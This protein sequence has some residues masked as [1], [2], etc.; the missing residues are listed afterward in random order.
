MGHGTKGESIMKVSKCFSSLEE[1]CRYVN[2][3]PP[4]SFPNGKFIPTDACDSH[5]GNGAG[6]VRFYPD[7][8]GG[9][10][11]NWKTGESAC[12]FYDYGSRTRLTQ[13]E[14]KTRQK[15]IREFERSEMKAKRAC[16]VAVAKVAAEI[17]E[18]AHP[19][20]THPYLRRKRVTGFLGAPSVEIDRADA[21]KL[22]VRAQI[23]YLDGKPQNLQYCESRLL[24]VPLTDETGKLKSLQFIDSK[25]RKTILKGTGAKGLVWRPEDLELTAERTAPIALCEGVATA[26][27]VRHLYKVPCVAAISACNLLEAARIMRENFPASELWIC[28]DRDESGIGEQKAREAAERVTQ[29]RL[30]LCP[31]LSPSELAS[32]YR[33]TGSN[34]CTDYNDYMIAREAATSLTVKNPKENLNG[35]N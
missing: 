30:F 2:I 22:L 10:T 31:E 20:I 15:L 35:Y 13:E 14:W 5:R 21:Q 18:A 16:Q 4:K 7:G 17:L 8:R 1:A 6:R 33:I 27:S 12:F 11:Y 29:S 24:C 19:A 3:C 25:G 26:L 23:P 34:K 9:I 28:A 32:L